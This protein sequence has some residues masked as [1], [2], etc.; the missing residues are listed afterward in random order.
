MGHERHTVTVFA[1]VLHLT[2]TVESGASSADE[3]HIHPG[4][5]GFW[6]ARMLKHLDERPLLCGPQGGETGKVLLGLLGQ[7]GMDTSTVEIAQ[8]TPAIIQD[9]RSGDREPIAESPNV[10]LARHEIDDI[11][12][13]FLDRALAS[14]V[15]VVT[16]QS[17][18][19]LPIDFYKRLGHDLASAE[20]RVVADLHGPELWAFLEGG[21][22]DMLKV[23]DEDLE[24]DGLLSH[25]DA[26]DDECLAALERLHDSGAVSIVLSRQ[27]KT[28]LARD[29]DR[30]YRATAPELDP[31]DHRGAGDSMTAGLTVGLRRELDFDDTVRLGCAAGAANVTRHGL[32]S[33]D[34]GLVP[35]LAER[36]KVEAIQGMRA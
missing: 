5:Q 29:G 10:S 7:F 4:G 36:T 23:S 8:A 17:H 20:V 15:A 33:A 9:R 35:G 12:G 27:H 22:I 2:V 13:R 1:P 24:C 19:I 3:I 21:P 31:A 28:A 11:Y 6:I 26:G 16:G 34:E 18:E 30:L 25:A 14:Q 32:G